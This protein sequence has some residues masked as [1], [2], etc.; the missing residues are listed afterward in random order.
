[1]SEAP[2]PPPVPPPPAPPPP[3]PE[4]APGPQGPGTTRGAGRL[5]DDG[6]GRTFPCE[7]CGA[8]VEFDIRSQRMKCPFCSHEK[9][10]TRDPEKT[11]AEQDYEARLRRLAE[12]RGSKRRDD[13]PEPELHEVRCDA[14]GA[15]V[16]FH[17]TLTATDCAFC[18]APVAREKVHD[19]PER[20]P[21]DGVL[22]FMV[23]QRRAKESLAAWIRSRWFAP[24]EFKRRGIEGRFSGVYVPYWTFDSDT[25]SRYRGERGEHYYVTVQSGNTTR[26]ERRTRWYPA[27]GSFRL[28]FDDVMVVAAGKLPTELLQNLEPWPLAK[29]VPFNPEVLSG[30][31][32]QTY[33]VELEPGFSA[34]KVRMDA[35]IRAE[36]CRQIGGDDQRIHSIDSVYDQI[37][38]KHVLLPVWLLSYKYGDKTHRVVVNACTGE[39]QGTRPWSAWKIFFFVVTLLT[40]AVVVLAAANS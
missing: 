21:V 8:D 31:L 16:Q 27:A 2:P 39:V 14:C 10:L 29:L 17:G 40:L 37:T 33:D 9:D 13:R 36:T 26:Q 18:G 30:F 38:Y 11:V 32:A 7:Q 15:N 23:E 19:C 5:V 28:F 34:A 24:N 3:R 1:M 35:G 22:P 6:K 25:F 12:I 4:A 20:V